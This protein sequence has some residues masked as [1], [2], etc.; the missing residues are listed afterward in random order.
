VIAVLGGEKRHDLL[1][2]LREATARLVR[3]IE[4][5]IHD[6]P[7]E[8]RDTE[9]APHLRMPRREALEVRVLRYIANAEQAPLA[10]QDAKNAVVTGQVADPGSRLVIDSRRDEALQV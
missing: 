9:E 3:Q 4:I 6:V 1:V 5:P 8:D 2:V 10:Q 7:H